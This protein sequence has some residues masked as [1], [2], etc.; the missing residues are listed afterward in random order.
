MLAG[1]KQRVKAVEPGRHSAQRLAQFLTLLWPR[2][3]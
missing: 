1:I 3:L 2:N